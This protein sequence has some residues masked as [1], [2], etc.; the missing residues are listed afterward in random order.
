MTFV[1]YPGHGIAL[2]LLVLTIGACALAFYAKA[3]RRLPWYRWVLPCLQIVPALMILAILWDPSRPETRTKEIPNTILAIFD[4]SASMAVADAEAV[5][6][7]S[8]AADVFSHAFPPGSTKTPKVVYYSFDSGV[9]EAGGLNGLRAAG[10]ETRLWSVLQLLKRHAQLPDSDS[11]APA[12][13]AVVFTDGQAFDR[14][15]AAE[16]IASDKFPVAIVGVGDVTPGTDVLVTRIDAPERARIDSAFPVRVGVAGELPEPT[17]V[18]VELRLD[19]VPLGIHELDGATLSEG[20]EIAFT[21]PASTL[22]PHVLEARVS[23]GVA[24]AVTA[25]NVRQT[26]VNVVEEPRLRVLFYTQWLSPDMGKLR[27][28]LAREEKVAMEFVSDAVIADGGRRGRIVLAPQNENEFPRT[29]EELFAYDVIVLGP[30]DPRRLSSEQKESLYRFVVDRGGGLLVLPGEDTYDLAASRDRQIQSLLPGLIESAVGSSPRGVVSLDVTPEGRSLLTLPSDALDP[31]P[32]GLAPHYG[33]EAKP[34]ATVAAL[35]S[36]MPA[37]V[38]HRVGRGN[39]CMLNMRH[40]H[41][42]YREDKEGGDLRELTSDLVTHLGATVRDAANVEL[43][44]ERDPTSQGNAVVTAHV[45]DAPFQPASGATVLLT[46]GDDVRYMTEA[47][48]GEYRAFVQANSDTLVMSVEA[49]RDGLLLGRAT[50]SARLPAQRTEMDRVTLDRE[51][52]ETLSTQLGATYIDG[53]DAAERLAAMFPATSEVE[54][55]T[56]TSSAWRNWLCLGVVCG[57]LTLG[58]FVRRMMGLV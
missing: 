19:E 36:E 23:V 17:P 10:H 55:V 45:R 8:R 39:V 46:V 30:C 44:A 49:A 28:S 25:N 53:D 56:S 37:V 5:P 24:E 22:G 7:L 41:L 47:R 9:R 35:L 33:I 32:D 50:T 6:R 2:A 57:W 38:T 3:W 1:Q 18:Y 13:G 14:P 51:Y 42:L 15:Q 40:L 20:E 31:V 34:A 16:P 58:W 43:F 27:Q 52:L 54:Q 48:P 21:A 11:Q 12:A 26:V 4:T 29:S